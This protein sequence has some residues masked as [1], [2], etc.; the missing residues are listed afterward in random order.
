MEKL[1]R[2]DLASTDDS[3]ASRRL[4]YLLS[5]RSL[6]GAVAAGAIPGFVIVYPRTLDPGSV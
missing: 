1:P 5:V 6:R 2:K 4:I 3:V